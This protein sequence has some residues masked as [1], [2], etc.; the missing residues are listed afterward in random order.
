M[1]IQSKLE[2]QFGLKKLG[3]NATKGFFGG[4]DKDIVIK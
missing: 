3:D 1:L 2:E 4:G